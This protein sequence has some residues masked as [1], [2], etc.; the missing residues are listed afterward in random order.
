M[1]PGRHPV[2]PHRGRQLE[3][4]LADQADD[5]VLGRR[6]DDPAD[7]GV[8]R[9]HRRGHQQRAA[10]LDEGL[11]GGL[12]AEQVALD[13]DGEQLVERP[14][15]GL[16]GGVE[17]TGAVVEHPG[18]GDEAVEPAEP[19]QRDVDG[20][21]VVGGRGDVAD[22]ADGGLAVVALDPGRPLGVPLEGDDAGPLRD[23]AVDQRPAQP[24]SRARHDHHVVLEPA[25]RVLRAVS[26]SSCRSVRAGGGAGTE[27]LAQVERD[28][29]R[30][31]LGQRG[32]L[33]PAPRRPRPRPPRRSPS[34]RRRRGRPAAAASAGRRPPRAGRTPRRSA[35]RRPS[36]G[37]AA[38][39]R[40]A[41]P[42]TPRCPAGRPSGATGAARVP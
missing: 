7:P 26:V 30:P 31:R 35:G 2:D 8:R 10:A 12:R 22:H 42:G 20:A 11:G 37:P 18:V 19:G 1:K 5:R 23:E 6:V 32:A 41:P 38:P 40:R 13:V 36:A 9:R 16:D 15:Q 25:H 39:R 21:R 17:E 29:D 33:G 4:E 34:G 14:L 24:R 28:L 27:V 3:R